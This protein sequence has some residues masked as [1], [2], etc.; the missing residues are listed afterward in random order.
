[1]QP[2]APRADSDRHMNGTLAGSYAPFFMQR[3]A[4]GIHT[5]TVCSNTNTNQE[6]RGT[7]HKFDALM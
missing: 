7:V 4:F 3:L 1:M 2:T 6:S 5:R